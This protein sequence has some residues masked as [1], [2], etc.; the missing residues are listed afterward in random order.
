MAEIDQTKAEARAFCLKNSTH[1]VSAPYSVSIDTV[2]M[3][4]VCGL[5]CFHIDLHVSHNTYNCHLV[6]ITIL[7]VRDVT[8]TPRQVVRSARRTI[9]CNRVSIGITVD[10]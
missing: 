8:I 4:H 3:V 9:M 10:V 2:N 5:H 1:V 6:E 7:N